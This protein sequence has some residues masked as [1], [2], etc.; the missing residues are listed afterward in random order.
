[1]ESEEER[2]L[3]IKEKVNRWW[4]DLDDNYKFELIESYY[5]DKAHLMG[6]DEMWGGLDWNDKWDIYR[7]EKDEVM[8]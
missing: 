3:R 8:V 2:Q 7:G 6:L 4:Y 5:P 1:M